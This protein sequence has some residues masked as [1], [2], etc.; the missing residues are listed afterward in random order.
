MYAHFVDNFLYY[1]RSCTVWSRFFTRNCIK[2]VTVPSD[3]SQTDIL[4][5]FY[6]YFPYT[7]FYFVLHTYTLIFNPNT[8]IQRTTTTARDAIVIINARAQLILKIYELYLLKKQYILIMILMYTTQHTYCIQ[9]LHEYYNEGTL[10]LC[11]TIS[12]QY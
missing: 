4:F 6:Y 3:W 2:A 11:K 5:F 7:L 1:A 8:P 9:Q 12:K 10:K